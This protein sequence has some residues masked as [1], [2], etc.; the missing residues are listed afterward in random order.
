MYAAAL[1]VAEFSSTLSR[2]GADA[3]L[4]DW[5]GLT[6]ADYAGIL[7]GAGS[8]CARASRDDDLV[9]MGRAL[10]RHEDVYDARIRAATGPITSP[11][12][13]VAP[14]TDERICT[15]AAHAAARH[16]LP[17]DL[18][19]RPRLIRPVLAIPVGR[20]WLVGEPGS[21]EHGVF[22]ARWLLLG[23]ISGG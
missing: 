19:P 10:A 13:A 6:A 15:A 7:T 1:G 8:L 9:A 17:T 12:D 16:R 2:R 4:H 22:D 18:E 21:G 3:S 20:L 23:W 14:T 5:R 11:P